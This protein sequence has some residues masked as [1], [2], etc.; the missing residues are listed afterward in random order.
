[1]PKKSDGRLKCLLRYQRI[2]A[3]LSRLASV[4]PDLQDFL[5]QAV[6]HVGRA[7]DVDRVK[8][9]RYRP[10]RGDLLIVA[11]IGWREGVV[12]RATLPVGLSSPPGRALQTG[13]AVAIADLAASKEYKLSPLLAEHGIRSVINA[14]I[15]VQGL[16]WGV[17]EV[18]SREPQQFHPDTL[19]F[20]ETVASLIGGAAQRK[21]VDDAVADSQASLG[22]ELAKRE[23]LLKEMQHRVKNN[24]QLII[25]MLLLQK[26]AADEKAVGD[27]L[28][29]VSER[30]TAIALAHDQL[31]P[32]QG[33]RTVNIARYLDALC[34]QLQEAAE[35]VAVETDLEEAAAPIDLAVCLGLIAN[36][37]ITNALKHA[38]NG[39]GTIRV[40]LSA[41]AGIRESCLSVID[42]GK[43]MGP[44]REGSS[45]TSLVDD[46]AAQL[47]GRVERSNPG[48][49]SEVKVI[50]PPFD[51]AEKRR[52]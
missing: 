17:L 8:I 48:K 13:R 2:V 40:R 23:T 7:M 12:G 36:E 5:D 10:E 19:A 25:S 43:G 38:F 18:D 20:V 21:A 37:L 49:G 39:S 24:F 15:A 46:L 32:G 44:P 4:D 1:M 50:F 33:L 45:G 16:V 42:D 14:P 29:L 11:G 52:A 34:R 28:Q 30:V 31:D 3:D 27:A 41:G 35:P 6:H 47:R 22:R 9:L 26:S 51:S